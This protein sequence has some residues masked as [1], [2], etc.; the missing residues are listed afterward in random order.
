MSLSVSRKTMG[1]AIGILVT[2]GLLKVLQGARTMVAGADISAPSLLS[3]I[4]SGAKAYSRGIPKAP[5]V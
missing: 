2:H 4:P 3:L 1:G 5:K